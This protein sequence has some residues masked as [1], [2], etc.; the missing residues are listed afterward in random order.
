MAAKAK[1]V[2][3]RVGIRAKVKAQVRAR[4]V[5]LWRRRRLEWDPIAR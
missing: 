2:E 3:A 1:E 5:G 4:T